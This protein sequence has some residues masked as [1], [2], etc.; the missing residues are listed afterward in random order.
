MDGFGLALF[1]IFLVSFTVSKPVSLYHQLTT[2]SSESSESNESSSSEEV[3]VPKTTLQPIELNTLGPD[4]PHQ[5]NNPTAQ[6]GLPQTT[7]DPSLT[8]QEVVEFDLNIS[9]VPLDP[10]VPVSGGPDVTS[11][12]RCYMFPLTSPVPKPARGDNM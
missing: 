6:P 11:P 9:F 1:G 12:E 3:T 7:M 5:T 4:S 2:S 8:V 10:A